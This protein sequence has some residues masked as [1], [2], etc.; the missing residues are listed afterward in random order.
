MDYA[1]ARRKMVDC[2]LRPSKVTDRR[3]LEAMGSIPRE[4]F[5]PPARR[6]AA[7]IDEDLALPGGRALVEPLVTARLIQLAGVRA[8]ARVLLLPGAPGYTAAVLAR[9]GAEVVAV[10]EDATALEAARAALTAVAPPGGLRLVAGRLVAGHAEAAPYDAIVIEGAVPAL[11]RDL[12][13][14]LAEGGRMVGVVAAPG[15]AST[16]MVGRRDG[17]AFTVTPAFDCATVALAAF[18]PA[19]GFAF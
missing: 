6:F 16:A 17:A 7:Y 8:G 12:V 10:E 4:A 11:P 2:Q 3:L 1:D 9:M 15:R 18:A 5:L 14:Q 13:A 19:P